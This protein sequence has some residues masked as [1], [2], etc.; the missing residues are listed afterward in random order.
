[1]FGFLL[2]FSFAARVKLYCLVE[3]LRGNSNDTVYYLETSDDGRKS[4]E[5]TATG[6]NPVD[7]TPV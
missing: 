3:L 7:G 6:I 2:G 1:L 5:N 4:N